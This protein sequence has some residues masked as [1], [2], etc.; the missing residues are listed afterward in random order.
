MR[1]IVMKMK[2]RAVLILA[3]GLCISALT[4][5][6]DSKNKEV[7]QKNAETD[8]EVPEYEYITRDLPEP[9]YIEAAEAFS[10]GD[11]TEQNPYQIASAAELT[12]LEELIR[13]EAEES[14]QED[15]AKASYVLTADIVLNDCSDFEQWSQN[16]PEYSWRPIGGGSLGNFKGSF[17]GNGYTISGMLR[18]KM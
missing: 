6:S 8:Y 18:F 9:K 4:G 15:Y 2:K 12:L 14:N 3:V 16:G 10:G 11:G 17:D 7:A 5:C 1:D 13:K